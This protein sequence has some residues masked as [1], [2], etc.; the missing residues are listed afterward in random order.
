MT[1]GSGPQAARQAYIAAHERFAAESER[2]RRAE[3]A[4]SAPGSLDLIIVSV[5]VA[6]AL[7]A[8]VWLVGTSPEDG[9]FS[10]VMLVGGALGSGCPALVSVGHPSP[11]WR[12]PGSRWVWRF[13]ALSGAFAAQAV[14]LLVG[15]SGWLDILPAGQSDRLLIGFVVGAATWRCMHRLRVVAT[16]ESAPWR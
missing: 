12:M 13:A 11:W 2:L 7:A 1:S 9:P 10:A 5:L 14:F 16:P 6:G 3:W 15:G 4:R 8:A